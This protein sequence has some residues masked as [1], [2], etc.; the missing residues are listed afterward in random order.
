MQDPTRQTK[1][2]RVATTAFPD[3]S[4]NENGGRSPRPQ[5]TVAVQVENDDPHPQVLVAFGFLITNCA[6]STP[7][8]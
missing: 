4:A 3:R 7:S 6:P 5:E 1:P 2:A 8:V